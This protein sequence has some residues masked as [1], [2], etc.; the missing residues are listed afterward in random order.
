MQILHDILLEFHA[1]PT[2]LATGQALLLYSLSEAQA[3]V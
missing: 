2:I 1:D 3:L